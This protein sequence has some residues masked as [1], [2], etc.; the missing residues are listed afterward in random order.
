MLKSEEKEALLELLKQ[1]KNVK[2]DILEYPV[3]PFVQPNTEFPS[4]EL[5]ESPFKRLLEGAVGQPQIEDA[6]K[7]A[8]NSLNRF[9][10]VSESFITG[11]TV[12]VSLPPRSDLLTY[13]KQLVK[14]IRYLFDAYSSKLFFL[15]IF[16]EFLFY[17]QRQ[18]V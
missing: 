2:E 3:G 16:R 7:D 18:S 12:L 11:A 8:A 9:K 4:V 6:I 10:K 14:G 17:L 15:I 1:N 5:P 13:H